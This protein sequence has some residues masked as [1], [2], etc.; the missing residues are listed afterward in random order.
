MCVCVCVCVKDPVCQ[1]LV[2]DYGNNLK[3]EKASMHY[4][5][6]KHSEFCSRVKHSTMQKLINN[7]EL[8]LRE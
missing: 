5:Q 7:N 2:V 6:V 1:I 4:K 3:K 8:E